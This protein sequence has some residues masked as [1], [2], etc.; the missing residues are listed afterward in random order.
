[1][2]RLF[3]QTQK[4]FILLGVFSIAMGV[5][6]AIVVVYLRQLYY[7]QGF[8]FPLKFL[9]PEMLLTEW[10]REI[11]TLIMLVV[12]AI[13]AGK[14]YL[15]RFSYFLFCFAIWDITYYV[16]LKLFLDWPSSFLSWDIL[17][18]IPVPWISP[19]LAPLICS[20][21]MIFFAL[22]IIYLKETVSTFKIKLYEWGLIL[23]GATLIFCSFIMDYFMLIM[24]N[25]FY[26]I[27]WTLSKNKYFWQ[28]ISDYNP[29]YYNWY[30]FALGEIIILFMITGLILRTKSTK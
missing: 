29:A 26:S 20:L 23:L 22:S 13:I 10:V 3:V 8:C 5:L 4:I 18:L 24:Q 7:P 9:S 6:E 19:V 17:F 14:D 28:I 11:A 12:I 15:H 1:M 21:T 30:L 25:G 16:G 27:F 2:K